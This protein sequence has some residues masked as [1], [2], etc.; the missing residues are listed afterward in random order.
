MALRWPPV[1]HPELRPHNQFVNQ[2]WG[3]DRIQTS[4]WGGHRGQQGQ[5]CVGKV[6][7]DESGEWGIDRGGGGY[8]CMVEWVDQVRMD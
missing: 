3:T 4:S 5:G 7:V 1:D 8:V 2:S 6:E